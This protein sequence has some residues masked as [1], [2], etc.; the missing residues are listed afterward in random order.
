MATSWQKAEELIAKKHK[1]REDLRKRDVQFLELVR[2]ADLKGIQALYPDATSLLKYANVSGPA[3]PWR[4]SFLATLCRESSPEF[5]SSFF[6][7]YF[8]ESTDE[9]LALK[10]KFLQGKTREGQQLDYHWFSKYLSPALTSRVNGAF[11]ITD[12]KASTEENSE[13]KKIYEIIKK[14]HDSLQEFHNKKINR[15]KMGLT[16]DEERPGQKYL[17]M[18]YDKDGNEIPVLSFVEESLPPVILHQLPNLDSMT[19]EERKKHKDSGNYA[20]DKVVELEF[21]GDPSNLLEST[22]RQLH[23]PEDY[24][25]ASRSLER[26]QGEYGQMMQ[27]EKLRTQAK[28]FSQKGGQILIEDR[29]RKKSLGNGFGDDYVA[30]SD[31]K[32]VVFNASY[33]GSLPKGERENH[34]TLAHELGH[35]TD[36]NYG[37]HLNSY[38]WAKWAYMLIDLGENSPLRNSI[39]NQINPAYPME[40]YVD[41]FVANLTQRATEVTAKDENGNPKDPLLSKIYDIIALRGEVAAHP[42]KFSWVK[43]YMNY[44][45]MTGQNADLMRKM[46]EVYSNFAKN[47]RQVYY[48]S[49]RD[50]KDQELYKKGFSETFQKIK[51]IS[52]DKTNKELEQ[53]LTNYLTSMFEGIELGQELAT[54]MEQTYQRN[55]QSRNPIMSHLNCLTNE[56]LPVLK[57]EFDE[58]DPNIGLYKAV[59]MDYFERVAKPYGFDRA[60]EGM[61]RLSDVSFDKIQSAVDKLSNIALNQSSYEE[62]KLASGLDMS[63]SEFRSIYAKKEG[64]YT[65]AQKTGTVQ[66]WLEEK[67]DI[68]WQKDAPKEAK[69]DLVVSVAAVQKDLFNDKFS[70]QNSSLSVK[71]KEAK[72]FVSNL[73]FLASDKNPQGLTPEMFKKMRL[74]TDQLFLDYEDAKDFKYYENKSTFEREDLGNFIALGQEYLKKTGAKELPKELQLSS[75]T[76]EAISQPKALYESMKK[77]VGIIE[78]GSSQTL[79]SMLSKGA[80]EGEKMGKAQDT[81]KTTTTTPKFKAPILP[82][83]AQH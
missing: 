27:D 7:A 33:Y 31:R 72:N 52:G 4:D 26:L 9:T 19:E 30:Y 6:E 17:V 64:E 35:D 15:H 32:D 48:G 61:A 45:T 65:Q 40:S 55:E 34:N 63:I 41:E 50:S 39:R 16:L 71:T 56:N 83:Q 2:N 5:V 14:Q 21:R 70:M 18:G 28:S 58:K 51:E 10:E 44:H 20:K 73:P 43:D 77:Y 81:S 22:Y 36:N 79:T 82:P 46:H 67:R 62:Q 78:N 8:P 49:Q 60:S 76:P 13:K 38:D 24:L 29:K 12:S 68:A 66:S 3:I 37:W 57:K 80:K 54:N 11:G 74:H 1:A 23:F 53:S 25:W 75:I 59:F 47:A 42:D 69:Q